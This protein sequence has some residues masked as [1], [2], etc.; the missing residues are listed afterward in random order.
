M[1]NLQS[2][3][4]NLKYVWLGRRPVVVTC[5]LSIKIYKKSSYTKLFTKNF[6]KNKVYESEQNMYF[7]LHAQLQ[8]QWALKKKCQEWKNWN[9]LEYVLIYL[10]FGIMYWNSY[11]RKN[12]MTLDCIIGT[13]IEKFLWTYQMNASTQPNMKYECQLMKYVYQLMKYVYQLMK[14]VYQLCSKIKQLP[15]E[16]LFQKWKC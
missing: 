16:S 7:L 12:G 11:K 3:A 6:E 15:K 9:C 13:K 4:V 2:F 14:Y 1:D 8:N 10:C 5:V